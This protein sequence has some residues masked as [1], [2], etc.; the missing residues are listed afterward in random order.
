METVDQRHHVYVAVWETAVRQILPCQREGGSIRDPCAV[1]VVKNNDTP[2]DNNIP[3]SMKI[4]AAKTFVNYPQIVKFT[5]VF[6]RKT[7]LLNGIIQSTILLFIMQ[8]IA[9]TYNFVKLCY[10]SNLVTE[11]LLFCSV[12]FFCC[13]FLPAWWSATIHLLQHLGVLDVAFCPC[14]P[15]CGCWRKAVLAHVPAVFLLC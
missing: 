10:A 15:V 12:Y 8:L 13:V 2:I 14:L 5:E 3:H 11:L 7:F 9:I 6:T 4:V 1:T